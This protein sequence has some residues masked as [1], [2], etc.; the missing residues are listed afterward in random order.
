MEDEYIFSMVK[1]NFIQHLLCLY[2]SINL[3]MAGQTVMKFLKGIK[4]IFF[5]YQIISFFVLQVLMYTLKC[6]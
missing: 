4:M 1:T 6:K 3:I 2:I 5:Y